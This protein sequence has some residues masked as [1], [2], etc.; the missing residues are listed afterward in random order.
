M[1]NLRGGFI[2][3][4]PEYLSSFSLG[5]FKNGEIGEFFNDNSAMGL[6]G[7]PAGKVYADKITAATLEY[8]LPVVQVDAGIKT[9]P[10]LLRDLWFSLFFDYGNVW[11]SNPEFKDFK[12]SAGAE[13]HL[14]FT[15]G[16]RLDVSGYAGFARGFK[17]YGEDQVYFGFSS[18]VESLTNQKKKL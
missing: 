14:K 13:I 10:A 6:R 1:L 5:K 4:R 18:N 2:R 8:R 15:L 12:Y 9:F 7:F 16:Y 3:N 17:E 11:D